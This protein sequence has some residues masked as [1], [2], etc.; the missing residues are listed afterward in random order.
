MITVRVGSSR[1]NR[2][3]LLEFGDGNVL[4]HVIRR[5]ARSGFRP[6]VCTSTNPADDVIEAIARR[7]GCLWFRG[8]ERDKLQRWRDACRAHA[9]SEFHTIDADDP[10]FDGV[11]GHASLD[12]LRTARVDIVYPAETTY[13]ASVGYS[14]T[15][16]VVERTCALKTTDDTE[17]MWYHVEKV[18]GLRKAVLQVADARIHDVRLTLDYEEDY[19]LLRSVLRLVGPWAGRREIENLFLRNPDLAAVNWFRN[20]AWKQGQEAKRV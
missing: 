17:M 3:C 8:S 16:D 4:E 10:F 9:V 1:L 13:L 2:K 5:A 20:E 19:W 11:L 6:L 15:A 12:L 14:L 7:E 18:P